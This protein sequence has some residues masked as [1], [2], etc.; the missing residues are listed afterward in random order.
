MSKNYY[1]SATIENAK[2]KQKHI[3]SELFKIEI[4]LNKDGKKTPLEKALKEAIDMN[5]E[6]IEK[7]VYLDY[8][9]K[10]YNDYINFIPEQE[11][12]LKAVVSDE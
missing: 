12:E 8:L 1:E 11:A 2:N 10:E 7:L 6:L 9:M 5:D 3:R 4:R